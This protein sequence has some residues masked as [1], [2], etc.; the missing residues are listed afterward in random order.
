MRLVGMIIGDCMGEGGQATAHTHPIQHDGNDAGMT[1]LSR[2]MQ[3]Q[4]TP[5]HTREGFT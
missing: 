2:S 1:T 3:R 5:L 4:H